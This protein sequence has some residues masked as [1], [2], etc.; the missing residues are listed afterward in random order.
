MNNLES[1]T[2]EVFETDPVKYERYEMAI[3][4]AL[5]D[6]LAKRSNSNVLVSTGGETPVLLIT[7]LG[8]GRGPL[9]AAVLR[10]SSSLGI[11]V[12]VL[13]VEKNVNAVITLRNRVRT[14]CW[15][16]VTV[17][18]GDMRQLKVTESKRA[19]IIV[20][21][22]LGSWGDNEL[23]P[24]CLD[25]SQFCLKTDGESLASVTLFHYFE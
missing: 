14:D 19:D 11:F 25:G 7:V 10:A 18:S 22:L 6:M 12:E 3:L 2:Y 9:V 4:S 23:S 15:T 20:S 13:A 16:N 5:K 21:E 24:E 17:Y 8:A 1:Q